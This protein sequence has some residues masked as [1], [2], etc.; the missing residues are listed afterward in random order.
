MARSMSYKRPKNLKRALKQLLGYLG[1]HKWLLLLVFFLVTIAAVS[2]LLGTFAIKFVVG[3]ALSHDIGYLA[4]VCGVT[5]GSYFLGV[6]STLAFSQIMVVLAQKVVYDMRKDLFAKIQDLPLRFFD[7]TAYG[8]IM[9]GFTNDVETVSE[10][11][12]NSFAA[13]IENTITLI[14]TIIC[15]FV[16]SWQ[17]SLIVMAFY[18]VLCVYL[19]FAS[20]KSKTYFRRQQESLGQLSGLAE[21]HIRGMK[22]VK[23]FNHEK[24]SI[25]EFERIAENLSQTSTK[26]LS[27]SNSMVPMVMALSYFNY[28]IIAIL[29]GILTLNGSVAIENLASYLVFV[30]QTSMPINRVTSQSNILLN[31]LASSERIFGFIDNEPE[32]DDGEFR[33]VL[34]EEDGKKKGWWE[35]DG[36][37]IPLR[38]KVEFKDVTFSYDGKKNVLKHLSLVASPGQKIAF[39][40]ST[41]AGKTT[42]TNLI[43]RFYDVSEG[44]IEYDGIDVRKIKKDSLRNAMALVLQD[45]H[46]FTGTVAENIR[47]GNLG[48]DMEK[49]RAAARL[50][51]ADGFISRLGDGYETMISSDGANLSQ[52]QR[53]LLA[54]ARAAAADPPVLILDEATS[55]VDTYTEKLIEEGMDKL[56]E[57]RTVFVIAHRLSTVRNADQII[58]LENGE[59]VERGN[60][61]QLLALKGRYYQLYTG[62]AELA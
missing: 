22:A 10:A 17:L 23:V 8:D 27:Y 31:A 41:G 48:A 6:S 30:R 7:T 47:F 11:L 55:S 52:G 38:G 12:N 54:I 16:L 61:S 21:E 34:S 1:R 24:A 9:S 58:V 25:D 53:Q 50:A 19:F 36:Q 4:L 28:A 14:G 56:M 35:K 40:G 2:N 46:L 32:I 57:N 51:D 49:V 43:N 60:H 37:R 42:V 15:I 13:L 59:V 33:L 3:A 26:A 29:G 39:V 45:T 44:S 5:A 20:K 62:K 18:A